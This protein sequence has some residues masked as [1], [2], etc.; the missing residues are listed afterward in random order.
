MTTNH[1][2]QESAFAKKNT[3]LINCIFLLI[4]IASYSLTPLFTSNQ[5]QYF[6][7]G[8]AQAGLGSLDQ[9]WLANTADPAPVFTAI[10]KWTYLL[11]KSNIWFHIY[12]IAILALYFFSL[13]KINLKLFREQTERKNIL[14][15]AIV[16]ILGNSYL[17]RYALM[18]FI[19]P[20]WGFL[21][22]G[23]VADQKI[24]GTVL[25][26]S[27]F[28][29]LFITSLFFFLSHKP[30]LAVLMASLAAVFH[31]T[32]LLSAAILVLSYL[33]ETVYESRDLKKA[34]LLGIAA[35]VF[36]APIVLYVFSNFSDLT[37]PNDA[38]SIL[39]N[40][41]IPHHALIREWFDFS[42]IIRV[43][44][45]VLGILA[46]WK[47]KKISIPLLVMFI[48]SLSLTLLQVIINNDQLALMFPW[49]I[50]ALLV[51][52]C[53]TIALSKLAFVMLDRIKTGSAKKIL[54]GGAIALLALAACFGI[55]RSVALFNEKAANTESGLIAWVTETSTD[56][57]NFLIPIGLETFR[58]ATLRPAYVDFFSIP[59]A[60]QD[61]VDWYHRVLSANKYYE[62]GDC[63]EL[64]NIRHDYK[65]THIVTESR[66]PQTVCKNMHLVYADKAY[67]VYRY[68]K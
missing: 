6:L 37:R 31:P 52:V 10:V 40:V 3:Y 56:K 49:R 18:H 33:L 35:L 30:Y 7:H 67:T 12:Y 50:S 26:P 23:G 43:A 47:E 60:S 42:A 22:D 8:M 2:Q 5:N 32:Y 48:F 9:D 38:A 24:L 13:L 4:F 25:Q 16:I 36:V 20:S 63:D 44:L 45:I 11:L 51:P 29:V 41:R 21:L 15:T 64:Y 34:F 62:D 1:P 28:G 61:V 65:I 46:I 68:G 54:L 55:Y 14:V 19:N 57:D 17:L 53:S 27:I 66:D 39:V 59:Y 58:T